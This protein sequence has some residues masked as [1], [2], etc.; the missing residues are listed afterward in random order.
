M[1][2]HGHRL[3]LYG[4]VGI[5]RPSSTTPWDCLLPPSF[6]GGGPFW[7]RPFAG[8]LRLPVNRVSQQNHPRSHIWQQQAGNM[9]K[10]P[11]KALTLILP[12]FPKDS[13][14]YFQHA[15]T[16]R[17]FADSLVGGVPRQQVIVVYTYKPSLN[18]RHTDDMCG[19]HARAYG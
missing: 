1:P 5:A 2:E 9:N 10:C 7:A 17:A 13:C 16:K 15:T 12:G 14:P 3:Y 11:R 8:L 6:Q 18:I 19:T 4:V